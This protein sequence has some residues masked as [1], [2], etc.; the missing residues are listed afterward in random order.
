MGFDIGTSSSSPALPLFLYKSMTISSQP[1]GNI[2]PAPHTLM[3]CNPGSPPSS[4]PPGQVG[5]IR[6][7]VQ[8]PHNPVLQALGTLTPFWSPSLSKF[9]PGFA[10]ITTSSP[11]P[12]PLSLGGFLNLTRIISDGSSAARSESPSFERRPR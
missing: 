6:V 11:A 3:V 10:R 2:A 4:S 1:S 9:A 5:S 7:A 8:V 12:T